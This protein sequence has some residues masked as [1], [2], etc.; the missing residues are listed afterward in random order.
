MISLRIRLAVTMAAILLSHFFAINSSNSSET[1]R[2]EKKIIDMHA[3]IAGIGAGDSGCFISD[4]MKNSWKFRIYMKSLGVSEK[5]VKEKGDSI[6]IKRFS[7]ELSQSEYVKAAVVLAMDGVIGESGGLDIE[8][9]EVYIPND[10]VLRQ[11]RKYDNLLFGA[12]INP[13][14]S[15]AIKRLDEIAEEG[16]VLLKWLPSIQLIDP[17]DERL[18]R[19]YLRLKELGLPLLIHVGDEHSFTKAKNEY[20]DPHR[21]HLPLKLGVTVIAAHAGTSGK[22]DGTDN[23]E[24]LL[25]MFDEYPNLYADISSLTQINKMGYLGRLL[26]HEDIHGRLLYGT[27]MPLIK[28]GLTSP[29]FH[30]FKLS[31]I[32]LIALFKIDN[33]W[34]RDVLLKKALGVPEDIFMN[35]ESVLDLGYERLGE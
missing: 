9:T 12:S 14:R 11:T 27:D 33:P 26:K 29:L 35:A 21:L 24:R 1:N 4:A 5:E 16:A 13:Y 8:R 28:T 30:I 31:P 6:I 10:Y 25:P 20:A 23:M 22:N 3:H 7:E 18:V 34:D 32:E 15:D 19:F 2:P 17:A